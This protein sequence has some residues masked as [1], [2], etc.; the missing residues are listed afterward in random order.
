MHK[1]RYQKSHTASKGYRD[2]DEE[3]AIV[4]EPQRQMTML[5]AG[6]VRKTFNDVAFENLEMWVLGRLHHPPDS[7]GMLH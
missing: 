1:V 4:G 2:G 3:D 6:Q 7:K 5:A